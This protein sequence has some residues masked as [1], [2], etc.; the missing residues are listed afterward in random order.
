VNSLDSIIFASQRDAESILEQM[1]NI[2]EE[3]DVVTVG[4][5]Y[6]LVGM[7]STHVD[8]TWGWG[9]LGGVE[10]LLQREGYIIDLPDPEPI[11]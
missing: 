8:Q 3:Y 4:D 5:L 10:V 9:A 1:V 6:T 7:R 11:Q 2:V